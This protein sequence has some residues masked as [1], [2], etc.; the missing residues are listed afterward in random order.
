MA[1]PALQKWKGALL[2]ERDLTL[3]LKDKAPRFDDVDNLISQLRVTCE[4]TIFLDFEYA[5][6]VGVEKHLWDAHVMIN[7][8]YRKIVDHYRQGDYKKHIVERR[9][10]EKRYA[11]FIKTSQFFYKGYIQ[12]LASHFSGLKELR[13]IAHR[14]SLS[15]LTAD[16]RIKVAPEVEESIDKSCHATLL[17]LGDLSRY[18]NNLRT[19]DRSWEAALGYYQLAN[20]L[21]PT[22][23]SAHNQ[24][25]VIA[26]ADGNHLDAVYHL[27]RAL[28]VDDPHLLA[29]GNLELEFKKITSAFDKKRSQPKTD[30]LSTL[31][32][33]FVL[34]HARFY[35]GVDFSTREELE[36]EVLSR[37][38]LLLK[39]QSFG[40][41]FEKLVLINI[42][43]EY[44]ATH[45]VLAEAEQSSQEPLQSVRFCLAFNIRMMFMLLQVLQPELDD[46]TTGE[47]LPSE[48]LS[49]N[50]SREKITAIT[51][52][53]L[54]ALRQYSVWLV[55]QADLIVGNNDRG[56]MDIHTKEMWKMYA[57]VLTK[58]AHLFPSETLNPVQYLLE[59]DETTVGF[60]PLRNPNLPSQCQ[61][62]TDDD[63]GLL[64]PRI[65]D[66]G[67]ER[68]LPNVEMLARIRDIICC[69][70]V[71]HLNPKYPIALKD[72]NFEVVEEG[73]SIPSIIHAEA[74]SNPPSFGS[75]MHTSSY[76]TMP[77]LS[78]TTQEPSGEEN[79]AASDFHNNIDTDMHR[80]VDDLVEPVESSNYQPSASHETSYGMHSLTANE[81]FPLISSNGFQSR[82]QSTPKMLPS[83]PGL[84]NPFTPQPNELQPTSPNRSTTARQ[85]SPRPFPLTT[86]EQQRAAAVALDQM[87]GYAGSARDSWGRKSSRPTSNNMSQSMNAIFQEQLARQLMPFSM[88]SSGLADSSSIYANSTPENHANGG[89]TRG[90]FTATSRNNSTIY[91]GL[92]DFD[93]NMMLQSSP[94]NGG[95]SRQ[96]GYSQPPPASQGG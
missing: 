81:V 59:E 55:S 5:T 7:Q 66:P 90:T 63:N 29:K 42:A 57:D 14:L 71:L 24:M 39:E 62:Y 77:E 11:D 68:N 58:L 45:K 65:T 8:R 75:T 32:W 4:G 26:L 87:T 92:S 85:L 1:T 15:T 40:E 96:E 60:K 80:M 84:W 30:S 37:I 47:D 52:R 2:I 61:L 91:S 22:D 94:W 86:L 36:N 72:E 50:Q 46:T 69:G 28:A 34:L 64:K 17:R 79:I 6:K 35:E 43:A 12:R 95:Q 54:P 89:V 83:L 82:H 67:I 76:S 88:S 44:F 23:G 48:S 93:T 74:Q 31:I 18:R 73:L 38:A 56:L 13:R 27:Y 16:E 78:N 25:A 33:W 21:I 3:L 20:D 41:I 53:V 10:L 70:L 19:K 49:S 51:R 9:K